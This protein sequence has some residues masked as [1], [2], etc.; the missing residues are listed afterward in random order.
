MGYDTPA[1][2]PDKPRG[3]PWQAYLDEF[4]QDNPGYAAKSVSGM[5]TT[6]SYLERVLKRKPLGSLVK[7]DLVDV[8]DFLRWAIGKDYLKRMMVLNWSA[9]ASQPW[10]KRTLRTDGAPLPMPN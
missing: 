3:K 5:K 4:W 8:A 2:A 6:F 10:R 7:R 9:L 1:K